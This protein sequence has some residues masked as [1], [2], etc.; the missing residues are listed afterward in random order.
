M[1]K[2]DKRERKEKKKQQ[3][4]GSLGSSAPGSPLPTADVPF[5]LVTQYAPFHAI[6]LDA[7]AGINKLKIS[8]TSRMHLAF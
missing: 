5:S 8:F 2:E 7:S 4:A 1:L 3:G 6:L